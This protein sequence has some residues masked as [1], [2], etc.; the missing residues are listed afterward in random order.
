MAFQIVVAAAE[1]LTYFR[2][3]HEP[4][5]NLDI[6]LLG[7][8]TSDCA[9]DKVKSEKRMAI[10]PPVFKS[11]MIVAGAVDVFENSLQ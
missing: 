7:N 8:V 3:W 1:V 4:N 9:V 6:V 2:L 11:V 5:A 10:A